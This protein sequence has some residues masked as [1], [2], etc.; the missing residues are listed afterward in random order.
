MPV[1]FPCHNWIISENGQYGLARYYF[2]DVDGMAKN[3]GINLDSEAQQLFEQFAGMESWKETAS[4][5]IGPNHLAQSL[6][7]EQK[8][9]DAIRIALMELTSLISRYLVDDR[10]THLDGE[11]DEIFTYLADV[12]KRLKE[13]SGHLGAVFVRFRGT[14]PHAEIPDK[15]DYE[16]VI[17]NTA[18]DMLMAPR[19]ARRS[20]AE[21]SKLPD[22]LLEA[23]TVF[24]DY[25]VNN[26]FIRISDNLQTEMPAL[27]LCLKILSGFR[28]ARNS[29]NSIWVEV[30]EKPVSVPL[31]NDENLYP[32]PNLTLV[33]GLNRLSAKTMESMVQKVDVWLRRQQPDS[34]VKKYAGVYNTALELPKLSA[35]L[36]KPPVEMNNVKWLISESEDEAI[37][38]EKSYIAQL[39]MA[40]AGASPQKVAKMIKSVYGEDYAKISMPVLDERLHL[41]SDLLYAAEQRPQKQVLSEELLG[42]LQ[43][44]LDQVKDHIIDTLHVRE[45]TGDGIPGERPSDVVHSQIFNLVSFYKSRS[46]ARKKM[47]GLVHRTID[48]T[49]RDY[50]ILAQDFRISL[51]DAQALVQK[52]KACFDQ[53]GRFKK[54][55]FFEAIDHFQQYEQKIFAFLWHHMK[56]AITAED[57]V[58]FLN[59]L[60]TLTAR[61]DQPKR[62]FKI[63]LEDICSDPD[64][65]Q[66]SDN[67]AVMLANL[68]LHRP[69][70]AL[71]DYEITPEDII[72]SRRNLDDM[73]VEYAAWRVDKERE[74]LFTKVQTIHKKM[75]EAL[76]TGKTTDKQLPLSILLNLERELY[77]FLALVACQT[78][79]SILRSA[80]NEYGD[81]TA[82]IYHLKE[83]GN[84]M[85]GL[86]QNFRVALHGLGSCG[87]MDDVPALEAIRMREEHFQRLKKDR[88][89]RTQARLIGEWVDEAVKLIKFRAA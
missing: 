59:A 71:A 48:F 2:E 79:K 43:V 80:A 10:F 30:G 35:Q 42:N 70:K 14:P 6:L 76:R 16:V 56:D 13:A 12:I 26:I 36:K 58:A 69:D 45:D 63:L 24:A 18:V 31:I 20:G 75:A 33:A 44:R 61:M 68:I 65:I 86:L 19:V 57:R 5:L 66:Y 88:Q 28:K 7:Q 52:L 32:D 23:F 87:A 34:A 38:L 89:H 17:G 3:D 83:S 9:F 53:G 1:M 37:T 15:C 41:S 51:Q 78:A 77:I 29:G 46:V 82:E 60:Q 4:D 81:P 8:R 50:D 74:Q 67:K 64:N 47:V 85:G 27:K 73:V 25:G 72:L 62:A 40:T 55:A 21:F 49:P 84:F 54:A 39:A 11:E 22:Q